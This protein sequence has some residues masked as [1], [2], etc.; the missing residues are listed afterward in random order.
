MK[1]VFS[2]VVIS[3]VGGVI[4][5]AAVWYAM[6]TGVLP[7]AGTV[8]TTGET[9]V[10]AERQVEETSATTEVVEAVSDSVVSIVVS[11]EYEQVQRRGGNFGGSFF[12][13]FLGDDLETESVI[14]EV[15]I[16]SGTGFVVT[17]DGLIVTNRHVVN[18]SGIIRSQRTV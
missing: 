5:G 3:L 6:G 16:A 10:T 18:E 17:E 15:E 14:E 7:Q 13:P 12:Q 4:G 9:Q 8:A 2:T 11:K 1:R